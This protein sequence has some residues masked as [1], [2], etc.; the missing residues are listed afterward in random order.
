MPNPLERVT[1][2][3]DQPV[4]DDQNVNATLQIEDADVNA[5]TPVPVDL[6]DSIAVIGA[7]FSIP[8]TLTVTNGAYTAKDVVGGLITLPA[9]V[10]DVGKHAMIYDVSLA[11]VTPIEAE[12]WFMSGDIATPAAD[13]AAFTLVAADEALVRGILPIYAGDWFNAE[14]AFAAAQKRKVGLL[15]QAGAATTSLYAYLVHTSTTSPGTTT[16]ELRV[17]GEYV[18]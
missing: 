2:R 7:G 17:S 9:M 16:M 10:S 6:V 12:L 11:G 4:H 1:Q 18:D 3:P 14:S 5:G 13:N 8:V 15:V